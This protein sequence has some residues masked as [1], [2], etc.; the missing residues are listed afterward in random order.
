[1]GLNFSQFENYVKQSKGTVYTAF[2]QSEATLRSKTATPKEKQKAIR[3]LIHLV[4]DAHQPMHVSRAEDKGARYVYE[5]P[6][7]IC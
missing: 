2:L 5:F 7:L 1:M 4:G 3:F 6:L